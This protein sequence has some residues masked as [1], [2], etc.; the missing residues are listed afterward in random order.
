MSDDDGLAHQSVRCEG[1]RAAYNIL[2]AQQACWQESIHRV[3]SGRCCELQS[4]GCAAEYTSSIQRSMY[5]Q[6]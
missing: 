3:G 1:A 5:R 2:H 6:Q 4:K